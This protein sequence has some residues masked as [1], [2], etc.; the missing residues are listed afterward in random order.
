ME[1]IREWLMHV[2]GMVGQLPQ[3]EEHSFSERFRLDMKLAKN[4]V[5]QYVELAL[6]IRW[7][8]QVL[9]EKIY[10]LRQAVSNIHAGIG[11]SKPRL[12]EPKPYSG[13]RSSKEL[14]NFLWDRSS[15]LVSLRL[16]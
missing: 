11:S 1:T 10:V 16:N 13:V 6:E 8:L 5:G 7:K 12:P 9:K 3:H 15:A 14:E 4:I 2:E